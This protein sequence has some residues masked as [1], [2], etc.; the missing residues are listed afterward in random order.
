MLYNIYRC[1]ADQASGGRRDPNI[2]VFER[3]QR[4]MPLF[5][6]TISLGSALPPGAVLDR[7][8]ALAAGKVPMPRQR[9]WRAPVMWSLGEVAGTIRLMPL[10]PPNYLP[11]QPVFIGA[12]EPEGSGS[13]VT[14]RVRPH[15]LTVG[16][17]AFLLLMD[18]A[19]T[20]GGVVQEVSRQRPGT[21]LAFALFGM[22][23]GAVAVAMFQ[24]G[25]MWAAADI[26]QLLEAA[27]TSN[28]QQAIEERTSA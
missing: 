1:Q 22:A 20:T 25:V 6:K 7:T 16:V 28:P 18:A 14:G 15:R 11:Q 5:T 8:R 12:I 10:S 24:L 26:R 19:M 27:A 13:R 2:L 4:G 9:R 21:A 3:Q 17:T 23:F